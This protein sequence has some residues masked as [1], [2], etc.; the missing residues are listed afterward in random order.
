MLT[1]LIIAALLQLG[2]ISDSGNA[3]YQ[4]YLDNQTQVDG[5]IIEDDTIL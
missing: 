1:A 5:I 3:T 4:H 2:I